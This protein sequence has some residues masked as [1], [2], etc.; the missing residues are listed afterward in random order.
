MPTI[1]PKW[2]MSEEDIKLHYITPAILHFRR[3]N[4]ERRRTASIVLGEIVEGSLL[5]ISETTSSKKNKAPL[6]VYVLFLLLNYS[7]YSLLIF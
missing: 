4:Y 5:K 1:K 2:Q 3:I 7:S 6:K